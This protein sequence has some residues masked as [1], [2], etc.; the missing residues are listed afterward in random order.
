MTNKLKIYTTTQCNTCKMA[1]RRLD[2]AGLPY[3]AV[4]IEEDPVAAERIKGEGATQAPVFG[5]K[6]KLR[7]LA[8]F[9]QIQQELA[10]QEAAS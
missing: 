4:N 1:M 10:E 8:E 7:T 6:G 9:P 3:T 5:W 2:D